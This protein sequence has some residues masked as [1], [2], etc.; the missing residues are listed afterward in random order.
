MLLGCI[1]MFFGGMTVG[2]SLASGN[3]LT[4]LIGIV[5]WGMGMY[6]YSQSRKK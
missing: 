3:P 5:A 4:F 2:A 1:L 6:H